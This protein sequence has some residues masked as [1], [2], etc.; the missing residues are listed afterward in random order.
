MSATQKSRDAVAAVVGGRAIPAPEKYRHL[1]LAV[2]TL[3]EQ[4]KAAEHSAFLAM[5]ED[6]ERQAASAFEFHNAMI[7]QL[8]ALKEQLIFVG[9]VI[10]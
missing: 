9:S 6:C 4:A 8:T 7:A 1:W 5:R 2:A 3:V 10:K